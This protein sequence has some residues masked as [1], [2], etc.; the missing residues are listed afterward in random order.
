[1]GQTCSDMFPAKGG[2]ATGMSEYIKTINCE[3][4]F[5]MR[6]LGEMNNTERER[7][8]IDYSREQALREMSRSQADHFLVH[9]SKPCLQHTVT[10]C[11]QGW[12]VA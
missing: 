10:S 9:H 5:S 7:H 3:G 1:M 12:P 8:D 6:T 4:V 2:T 11:L